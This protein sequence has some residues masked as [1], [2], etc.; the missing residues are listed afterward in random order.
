MDINSVKDTISVTVASL[1]PD[2]Y[3]GEM[4]LISSED[5]VELGSL[6]EIGPL[7]KTEGGESR[8]IEFKSV[9][10]QVTRTAVMLGTTTVDVLSA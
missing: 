8:R 9:T 2:V 3:T 7:R 5:G 4:A 10:R 6:E 1:D